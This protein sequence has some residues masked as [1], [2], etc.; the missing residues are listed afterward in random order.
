MRRPL[1]IRA[2]QFACVLVPCTSGAVD[3]QDAASA[4]NRAEIA[5]RGLNTLAAEFTQVLVNPMLGAPERTRGQLFLAPPNRFAMRFS[6]TG[7]RIVADG[8][9]LWLYAPTS[10]P[11]QVIKQP[12]PRSGIASPNLMG[13]F[14]D[15]PRERYEVEYLREAEISGEVADVVRLTPRDE[16]LGFQWAEIAVARSDGVLRQITVLE[17]SGQRRTLVF[18]AIRTDVEIPAGEL[19]FEVPSGTRVVVPND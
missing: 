13:Q 3:A 17:V 16:S 15:R 1:S 11:D 7:E 9:S 12:I 4:L 10:V 5:Y 19:T 18:R 6:S 14:V 2:L 8:T